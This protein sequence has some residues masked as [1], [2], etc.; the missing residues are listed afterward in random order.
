MSLQKKFNKSNHACTVTFCLPKEAVNGA[1]DIKLLG[2]F[3]DWDI[4]KAIPMKAKNGAYLAS[5]NLK[6]D[7]EY[8][9]RY[10]L[11]GAIWENDWEA[12]R[13]APTPFGVENSVVVTSV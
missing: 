3:N 12:D 5:I 11:D 8:Q 10:L 2:D 13:Y 7:Q 6:P 9:F 4:A 1:H